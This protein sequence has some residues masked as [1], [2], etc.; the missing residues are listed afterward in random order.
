MG[1]MDYKRWVCYEP[2]RLVL[3]TSKLD[4]IDENQVLIKVEYCGICHSDIHIIDGEWNSR[5]NIRYPITPGHE[6]IGK[7]IDKGKN[8]VG[9]D[10]GDVVGIPWVHSSCLVCENCLSSNEQF[11]EQRKITGIDYIGGYSQ[12]CVLNKEFAIPVNKLVNID[13][14]GLEEIA[15]LYCAGLTTYTAL[16]KLNVNPMM[17]VVIVGFGGLGHMAVQYSKIFGCHTIVLSSDPSKK[18]LAEKIGADE[19][20]TYENLDTI[21]KVDVILSTLPNSEIVMKLITKL[22]PY[23]KICFVGAHMNQIPFQ[24]IQLISKNLVLTGNA[25]GSRMDLI[26]TLKI[27][28]TKNIKPIVEVYEYQDL[29]IALDIVRSGKARLRAVLKVTSN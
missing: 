16:K 9:V 12:Y 20:I 24:P 29:P 25:V 11:C 26:E 17:R 2:Y 5:L 23:G 22:R 7:V 18:K 21:N 28:I 13:R 14:W 15:P 3:E 8:V 6:V 10:I 27:S 1:G 4:P 19:F